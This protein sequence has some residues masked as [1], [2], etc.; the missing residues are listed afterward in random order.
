MAGLVAFP[1]KVR[2]RWCRLSP[3]FRSSG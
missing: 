3:G 2:T 1:A